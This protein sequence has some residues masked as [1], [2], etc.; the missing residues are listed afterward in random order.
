M[1]PE[2]VPHAPVIFPYPV[3]FIN[4][5]GGAVFFRKFQGAAAAYVE[6]APAV[7][8]CAPEAGALLSKAVHGKQYSG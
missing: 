1:L 3:L 5:Q 8:D 6:D 7:L 4:V 2:C